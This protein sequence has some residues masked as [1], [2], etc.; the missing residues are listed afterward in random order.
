[1][2]W[3]MRLGEQPLTFLK[4]QLVW[5]EVHIEGLLAV[6]FVEQEEWVA[7]QL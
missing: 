4:L 5:S 3:D 6:F 7:S 1:M 2:A